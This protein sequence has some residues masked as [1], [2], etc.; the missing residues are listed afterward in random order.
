MNLLLMALI[1]YWFH[2][3]VITWVVSG[4]LRCV[5]VGWFCFGG[6]V[7]GEAKRQLVCISLC[8]RPCECPYFSI[9]THCLC[10]HYIC[11]GEYTPRPRTR[12]VQKSK[13]TTVPSGRLARLA[14]SKQLCQ[15]SQQHCA[16][17]L[18]HSLPYWTKQ[19]V[20]CWASADFPSFSFS[21]MLWGNATLATWHSGT[22]VAQKGLWL[23][24][25]SSNPTSRP[26][27]LHAIAAYDCDMYVRGFPPQVSS[28]ELQG[29]GCDM[30]VR[31]FPPQVSSCE[32]QGGEFCLLGR[33]WIL[34]LASLAQGA[35]D[36]MNAIPSHL[37]RGL[38]VVGWA[39]EVGWGSQ[40]Q[41]VDQGVASKG[42][43]YSWFPYCFLF[44]NWLY[45]K[46][47]IPF[48]QSQ[49]MSSKFEIVFIFAYIETNKFSKF[50][51]F[52]NFP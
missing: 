34:L 52:F 10:M 8:G 3:L 7:G 12:L 40:N 20:G 28:R 49:N 30:S 27:C 6:P 36:I 46:V 39:A 2:H 15:N 47:I 25:K 32:L 9:T 33:P 13:A 17:S 16:C 38:G 48:L 37:L 50:E 29:G 5:G 42:L 19:E 22:K 45:L 26:C 31:G 14:E 23:L 44:L 1:D 41:P 4:W 18:L 43:Y 35:W 24:Q 11:I 21:K 51:V